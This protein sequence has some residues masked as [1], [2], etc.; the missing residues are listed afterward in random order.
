[1]RPTPPPALVTASI[2]DLL[3][4]L[5]L[6]AGAPVALYGSAA[7]DTRPFTFLTPA[8]LALR[9]GDGLAA[10][11]LPP[12]AS[13]VLHVRIDRRPRRP[14]FPQFD[15]GD[16]RIS[17]AGRRRRVMVAG[18]EGRLT[19]VRVETHTPEWQ[20]ANLLMLEFVGANEEIGP[21]LA[22]AGLRP[23]VF[24]G[25]TDGCGGFGGNTPEFCVSRLDVPSLDRNFAA[26]TRPKWV[27]TDH[28]CVTEG[29]R[30]TSHHS[31]AA[32]ARYG[33]L[34]RGFPVSLRA[35]S[36]LSTAW[37]I[38]GSDGTWLFHCDYDIGGIR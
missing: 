26:G 3:D 33:P 38:Y 12:P 32:G 13:P 14:S 8:A 27:I 19:P 21:R 16:S 6:G 20:I 2:D 4:Q 15:D 29:G 28:L 11:K 7:S 10:L 34:D 18:V 5:D 9:A 25:V 31:F 24:V 1:M 23:E 17:I 30:V 36:R 37:G 22:A 35:V